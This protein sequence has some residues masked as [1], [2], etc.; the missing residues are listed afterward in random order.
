MTGRRVRGATDGRRS[1]GVGRSAAAPPPGRSGVPA[2]RARIRRRTVTWVVDAAVGRVL[3][4]VWWSPA[5]WC[6]R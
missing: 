6:L 2:V 5:R 3:T 1:P 4:S